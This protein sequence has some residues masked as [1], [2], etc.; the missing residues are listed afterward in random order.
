MRLL[1][2]WR[3]SFT[4]DS[5]PKHKYPSLLTDPYHPKK[6]REGV[7]IV[8]VLVYVS[9]KDVVYFDFLVSIRSITEN[10]CS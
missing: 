5:N 7:K 8:Q 1:L 6:V 9:V 4:F 10:F 2:K 3:R